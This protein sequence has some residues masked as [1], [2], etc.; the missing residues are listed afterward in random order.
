[1]IDAEAAAHATLILRIGPG[2]L[3]GGHAMQKLRVFK[4]A[5][6]VTY[7]QSLGLPSWIT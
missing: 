6:T 3:F 4:V 1:M 7:F 5:G 2:V